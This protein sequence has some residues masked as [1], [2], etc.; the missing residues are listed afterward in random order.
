MA[1]FNQDIIGIDM[2]SAA[3]AVYV[4]GLGVCLREPTQMLVSKEDVRQV[5][6]LGEEANRLADRAPESIIAMPPVRDSAVTDIDLAALMMLAMAEKAT[7]RKK[8]M[9]KGRLLV[10]APTGLTHVEHAAL[11]SAA[12]LTGAKRVVAVNSSV[13]AAIGAGMDVSGA[14]A[15]LLVDLGGGATEIAVLA[16]SGVAASRSLRTAGMHFDEAII[17]YMRTHKGISIGARTAE[18]IKK[19]VGSAL[20][21]PEGST[22]DITRVRGR[23]LKTGRPME[24]SVNAREISEALRESI[25]VLISAVQDVLIRLPE[26]YAADIR[27]SG[28]RLTGGCALL[29]GL[30]EALAEETGLTVEVTQTPQDD[31]A[32]GLGVIGRDERL[33]REL[34]AAGSAIE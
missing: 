30:T 20:P 27:Q 31:V 23:E 28:I 9:E 33:L 2:G 7:G 4:D 25:K 15:M 24:I 19:T 13:A 16:L 18:E 26:E 11:L 22:G 1:I 3:T 34:I 12:N 29:S 21:P 5:A 17:R 10:S 8:P 32:A 14:Q 6:A